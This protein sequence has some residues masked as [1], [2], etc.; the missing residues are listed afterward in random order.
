MVNP[1]LKL[2]MSN[3]AQDNKMCHH[4]DVHPLS[5]IED[6]SY[7]KASYVRTSCM[8]TKNF[9]KFFKAFKNS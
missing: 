6:T 2:D 3:Y 4:L 1:N 9:Y 8:I 5:H 7:C